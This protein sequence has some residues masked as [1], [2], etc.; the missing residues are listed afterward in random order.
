M[1]IH[2]GSFTRRAGNKVYNTTVAFNRDG[3][4]IATYRK[5]HLFDITTPDGK[6]YKESD[7]VIAG[8]DIVTYQA[9]DI[10]IGCSICYDMRFA[11]LYLKLAA[12]GAQVIMLPAAFTLQTGKDHWD[13]LIRA[14][15]IE[16]QCYAVAPAQWG[17]Y[18][19]GA[20]GTRET[21]G[22]SMIVDPW[23]SGRWSSYGTGWASANI[24]VDYLNCIRTDVP[25]ASHR[26]IGS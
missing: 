25:V 19:D 20:G 24:D 22:H 21:G 12:A 3:E 9:D 23:A 14:R 11:E 4:V 17:A 6:D 7:T 5:I 16:T 1:F 15:A 18:P 10:T 2:G 26:R 8:S 13:T